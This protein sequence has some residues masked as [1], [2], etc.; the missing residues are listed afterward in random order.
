ML[1][2]VNPISHLTSE[3]IVSTVW[4]NKC[5]TEKKRKKSYFVAI[6]VCCVCLMFGALWEGRKSVCGLDT[7]SQE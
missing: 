3:S 6:L 4:S 2:W 5:L 1:T 7:F